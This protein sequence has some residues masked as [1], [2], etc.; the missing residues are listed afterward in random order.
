VSKP[1]KKPHVNTV[2]ELP[3]KG[4]SL[5]L[6]DMRA[7]AAQMAVLTERIDVLIAQTH[8]NSEKLNEIALR[9]EFLKGSVFAASI[10]VAGIAAF[11]GYVFKAIF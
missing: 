10:I 1:V 11:V 9:T 2:V 8:K 7:M 4:S 3:F 5:I 6:N